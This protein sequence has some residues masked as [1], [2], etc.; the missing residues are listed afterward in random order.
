MRKFLKTL[1]MKHL[2]DIVINRGF[3]KI[4]LYAKFNKYYFVSKNTKSYFTSE[5]QQK[6]INK[7]WLLIYSSH[8]LFN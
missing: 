4:I 3:I 1:P 7:Y 2:I 8:Y 6:S 5:F